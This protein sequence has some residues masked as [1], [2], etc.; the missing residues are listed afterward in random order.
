MINIQGSSYWSS[1]KIRLAYDY[2]VF[3]GE[4]P[5]IFLNKEHVL[6]L[7]Y[8]V[9]PVAILAALFCIFVKFVFFFILCTVVP[10]YIVIFD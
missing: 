8:F 2:F 5:I 3:A 10:Y 9:V 6:K 7:I 1:Y 4:Y